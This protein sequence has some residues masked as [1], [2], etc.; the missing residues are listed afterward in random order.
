MLHAVT[1]QN[2]AILMDR[3]VG[4]DW[5]QRF[6]AIEAARE[7]QRQVVND[8]PHGVMVEADEPDVGWHIWCGAR[9]TD[10]QTTAVGYYRG[11]PDPSADEPQRT[12]LEFRPLLAGLPHDEAEF[13]AR[14]LAVD[15]QG[16]L[17]RLDALI[18]RIQGMSRDER[19]GLMPELPSPEIPS[20]TITFDLDR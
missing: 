4:P 19:W 17:E 10:E 2:L 15:M 20:P 11:Y 16:S 18:E 14:Y 7:Q 12:T 1:E 6:A 5:E 13:L 9:R 8:E 3:Y